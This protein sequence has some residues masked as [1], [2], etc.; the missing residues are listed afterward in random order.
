MD[1]HLARK[2]SSF[3]EIAEIVSEVCRPGGVRM[4]G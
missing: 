4:A 1:Y 2:I 3:D